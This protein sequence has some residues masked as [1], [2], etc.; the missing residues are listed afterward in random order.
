MLK[1]KGLTAYDNAPG[2]PTSKSREI[3]PAKTTAWK[4]EATTLLELGNKDG[5]AN[6]LEQYVRLSPNDQDIKT[7]KSKL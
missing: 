6:A 4:A 7:E 2:T 1:L 3:N 5:A